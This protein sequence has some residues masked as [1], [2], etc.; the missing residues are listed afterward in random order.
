MK[1]IVHMAAIAAILTGLAGCGTGAKYEFATPEGAGPTGTTEEEQLS[2]ATAD[3]NAVATSSSSMV[4]T[5]LGYD[6]ESL[7]SPNADL[8]KAVAS[9]LRSTTGLTAFPEQVVACVDGRILS[10]AEVEALA[11]SLPAGGLAVISGTSDAAVADGICSELLDLSVQF[12]N[13]QIDSER[14]VNG[15]LAV[16]AVVNEY[17]CNVPNVESGLPFSLPDVADRLAPGAEVQVQMSK[18]S[19]AGLN[20]QGAEGT[21]THLFWLRELDSLIDGALTVTIQTCRMSDATHD[22]LICVRN[23][24]G[25]IEVQQ[26]GPLPANAFCTMQVCDGG[27]PNACHPVTCDVE[28]PA[29]GGCPAG[30]SCMHD[31]RLQAK[32][33]CVPFDINA[34]TCTTREWECADGPLAVRLTSGQLIEPPLLC[35]QG[36]IQNAA[37]ADAA[38]RHGATRVLAVPY[39]D[40]VCACAIPTV[41]VR[42]TNCADGIDDDY[43]GAIDCRDPDCGTQPR[44]SGAE[45]V[46]GDGRCVDQGGIIWM[47]KT[48]WS[49]HNEAEVRASGDYCP[50]DC[51]TVPEIGEACDYLT[52]FACSAAVVDLG[53]CPYCN[54]GPICGNHFCATSRGETARNCPEDCLCGDGVCDRTLFEDKKGIQ[55]AGSTGQYF[56]TACVADCCNQDGECD[57][58]EEEICN[59]VYGDGK[60]CPYYQNFCNNDGHCNIA[61]GERSVDCPADCPCFYDPLGDRTNDPENNPNVKPSCTYD[62]LSWH[63]GNGICDATTRGETPQNCQ[64]DCIPTD[65]CDIQKM[66]EGAFVC[67]CGDG[68][69]QQG[70]IDNKIAYECSQPSEAIIAKYNLCPYGECVYGLCPQDCGCNNNGICEVGRGEAYSCATVQSAFCYE[71]ADCQCGDGTCNM[72]PSVREQCPKSVSRCAGF[73]TDVAS[74]CCNH[75][76]V[77]EPPEEVVGACGDCLCGNGYCDGRRS[78]EYGQFER[79]NCPTEGPWYDPRCRSCAEDCDNCLGDTLCYCGDGV[80]Q[81]MSYLPENPMVSVLN[82]ER[83]ATCPEDCYC[84]DGLCGGPPDED[85]MRCLDDCPL[86]ND[87][88]C[89]AGESNPNDPQYRYCP[90]DC[91]PNGTCNA[92]E[93]CDSCPDDCGVCSFCSDGTCNGDETCDWCPED[94]G[95]CPELCGNDTCDSYETC[96]LC[97]GD[98]GVCPF[99]N[100]GNCTGDETC[101]TCPADCGACPPI[102]GQ[103]GCQTEETCSSCPKD[104]GACPELCGNDTCDEGET[105]IS[106][107]DDCTGPPECG[108]G[109]CQGYY[110]SED[111]ATCPADCGEC[112]GNGWCEFDRGENNCN[113]PHDCLGLPPAESYEIYATCNDGRDNDC[114]GTL[115]FMRYGDTP[116][117]AG[118]AFGDPGCRMPEETW[119]CNTDF[120]E[121]ADGLVDFCDPDC[122]EEALALNAGDTTIDPAICTHPITGIV[123]SVSRGPETPDVGRCIDWID[124][125][126]DALVDFCRPACGVGCADPDCKTVDETN[127]G[128]NPEFCYDGYDNDCNGKM[129]GCDPDCTL[130]TEAGDDPVSRCSNG[131]DDDCDG[132]IDCADHPDCDAFEYC[133][134]P[135]VQPEIGD[136][137]DPALGCD[138]CTDG[139]DNDWDG[140]TDVADAGCELCRV[141]ESAQN[142][143]CED[144]MDNDGNGLTDW[145]DPGCKQVNTEQQ[146]FESSCDDAYDND[147]DGRTDLYDDDCASERTTET[148][149]D[150]V[151]NDADGLS[152]GCD[153]ECTADG[154]NN[155]GA[156]PEFCSDWEDNDCD[157]LWDWCDPECRLSDENNGGANP[158]YCSDYQDNDC[159]GLWDWCDPD[160]TTDEI[161]GDGQDNDCDWAWD[162]PDCHIIPACTA[163]GV[164]GISFPVAIT[165]SQYGY[166]SYDPD[167]GPTEQEGCHL[168]GDSGSGYCSSKRR[169]PMSD[170]ALVSFNLPGLYGLELRDV[171][172]TCSLAYT[173]ASLLGED[174]SDWS[175]DKACA[176]LTEQLNTNAGTNLST[177]GCD[178][179]TDC[180]LPTPQCDPQTNYVIGVPGMDLTCSEFGLGAAYEQTCPGD[181]FCS[182]VRRCPIMIPELETVGGWPPGSTLTCSGA[183]KA[184]ISWHQD[185]PTFDPSA[186]QACIDMEALNDMT[187]SNVHPIGCDEVTDCCISAELM[188]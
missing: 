148:C 170:P 133:M 21:L 84:G 46:C 31:P 70:F 4:L 100:D 94:C 85:F 89:G 143:N 121:D 9:K 188:P 93:T 49:A 60:D 5:A 53:D 13:C 50:Q 63:C 154:E 174:A 123:W 22:D 62:D 177:L 57:P 109:K 122:C 108:N 72:E 118:E 140:L 160:C 65:G 71:C 74:D 8:A 175:S 111:C 178:G 110:F 59:Y 144:W 114:N 127:A 64:H 136:P 124:N 81:W 182:N 35:V 19:S 113:C 66:L 135:Y 56:W 169:C 1:T 30:F 129:D 96:N 104:C 77:C 67:K 149:W 45:I 10:D 116:P 186:D 15:T 97:P 119:Y 39:S 90:Q 44:C 86:C 98:C 153:P 158:E 2:A 69:W 166:G 173:T 147:C 102:C 171:G 24:A 115:D 101:L 80:C 126:C 180:C 132:Y 168:V 55:I 29:N 134:A 6:L 156:N 28:D 27:S 17:P 142:G 51:C 145:C 16:D 48:A 120:D 23:V 75:N 167:L 43:D 159:D 58:G 176:F 117:A 7:T 151:D 161:C 11:G 37:L 139:N 183:R 157:G 125:D 52:G 181:G 128:A 179:F 163:D 155:G 99:C 36:Q 184:D 34:S 73:Y 112:C 107:P 95:A 26:D 25:G 33:C 76:N 150:S 103:Y 32:G 47:A 88:I 82:P 152:D 141:I 40:P 162:E 18:T 79:Y 68:R 146:P 78:P 20:V 164:T 83:P 165:C 138:L 172:L 130:A 106:C 14:T 41:P 131:M 105:R 91:C 61:F 54:R 187:G 42:E 87:G 185:D 3:A 38:C 92:G 137:E 12:Q